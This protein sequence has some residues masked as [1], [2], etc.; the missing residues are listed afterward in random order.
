MLTSAIV[1]VK[2]ASFYSDT[3]KSAFQAANLPPPLL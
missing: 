3:L 1:R 2:G